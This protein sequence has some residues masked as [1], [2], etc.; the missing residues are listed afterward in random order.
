MTGLRRGDAD[1]DRALELAA[2]RVDGILDASLDAWLEDHLAGCEAC[3]A[4]AAAYNEQHELFAALREATPE[5]P[6]DLWARTAAAIE[7][8]GGRS[9]RTPGWALPRWRALPLA[10]IAT[11]VAVVIVVGAGLLNGVALFRTPGQPADASGSPRPTPIAVTAG[12]VQVITRGSD[13][14]LELTTRRIGQV[15]PVDAPSCASSAPADTTR[16]PVLGDLGSFDAI[17]SP[18]QDHIVV[19]PRGE[20]ANG[21][22]VVPVQPPETASPSPVT[23][24]TATPVPET[25]APVTPTPLP[26]TPTPTATPAGSPST[27]PVVTPTPA[28]PATATPT[29]APPTAS[30]EPTPAGTPEPSAVVTPRPDGTIEIVHDVI[31]VGS[32]TGYSADGTRFAFTARPADGSAG[33]DVYV[34]R[35]SDTQA[36]PVT[37]D[38]GSVF[39]AWLGDQLLV[40]RVDG[41]TPST[42]L[43]DPA[44]GLER[45]IAAA[46]MWL[47]E[48]SPDGRTAVWWDGTLVR[49]PDGLTW[50]PSEGR[51][52]LG[53]WP[54][55]DPNATPV[56]TGT[57]PVAPS[58]EAAGGTGASS[59]ATSPSPTA[60]PS[61]AAPSL[62]VAS[63]S[64]D[65][66]GSGGPSP[67]PGR[68]PQVLAVNGITEWRV[69]WDQAGTAVAVW[70]AGP[71]AAG[72]GRLSLYPFDAATGTADLAKPLLPPT[73]AFG[74][75]AL[76]SGQLAWTAPAGDGATSVQVLAWSGDTVGQ[77]ELPADHGVT[78]LH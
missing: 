54:G 37:T 4:V 69:R 63:A 20:D 8:S 73:P 13:G 49:S 5:P 43:L 46:A 18:A 35:T 32:D 33:P 59:P 68:P 23:P 22:F 7:A 34:W 14:T 28:A 41:G 21:V 52:V 74:G 24:P 48:V 66:S 53:P 57:G 25:P 67:D 42:V 71:D 77:L 38:H 64:P 62:P 6:R 50:Q 39:A 9:R 47:P 27:A 2:W 40:S 44:A 45:P 15:C 78:V 65:A 70:I 26:V 72:A 29:P 17:L 30:P 76:R 12:D 11:A 3:S 51:L 19:I 31:P 36:F 1:H 16:L 75:F 56:P 58:E 10:P 61:P 55:V 60:S